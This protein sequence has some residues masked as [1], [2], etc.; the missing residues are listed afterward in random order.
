MF[1]TRQSGL[2]KRHRPCR[3][4]TL[5]YLSDDRLKLQIVV[6]SGVFRE[7]GGLKAVST[8]R[9]R[10]SWGTGAVQCN[11]VSAGTGDSIAETAQTAGGIHPFPFLWDASPGLGI[12]HRLR[13]Q[14]PQRSKRML[15]PR[16]DFKFLRAWWHQALAKPS[17]MALRRLQ[18]RP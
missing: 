2:L 15:C 5:S 16:A 9:R 14:S 8:R 18:F 6:T 13:P 10:C 7:L 12:H 3:T 1:Y 11:A 4:V 17:E